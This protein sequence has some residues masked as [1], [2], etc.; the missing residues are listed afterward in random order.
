MQK[1]RT[2]PEQP[3][4]IAESIDSNEG[5]LFRDFD[6]STFMSHFELDPIAKT[7]LALACR[8]AGKSDL[9]TKGEHSA[10]GLEA[11][12]I[13]P[14]QPMQSWPAPATSS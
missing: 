13:D 4:K 6:L 11:C 8:S 2:D 7:A 1:L 12:D 10:S 9:R 5:D 3:A 14:K